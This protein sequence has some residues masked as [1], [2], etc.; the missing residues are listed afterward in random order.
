MQGKIAVED[1]F[2]SP[3]FI[4]QMRSEL[5]EGMHMKNWREIVRLLLDV[6]DDRLRVMDANGVEMMILSL[7]SPGIQA[8]FSAERAV[9]LAVRANDHIAEKIK[10][11]PDRFR[12]FAALP[13][14]DPDAAILELR[15]CMTQM[16]FVGAL[17]NGYSQTDDGGEAVYL[18]HKRYRPFWKEAQALGAPVYIHP[19]DAN[20][21]NLPQDVEQPWLQ[22]SAWGFGVETATHALL[23]MGSGLFDEFPDLNLILGHMG[24]GLTFHMHRADKRMSRSATGT[25][26]LRGFSDYL[27]ENFHFTVSGLY[28]S[29]CLLQL[30]GE[31]GADRV[32]FATDYPYEDMAEAA[33]WFDSPHL[34]VSETD[35]RKIGRDNARKL[36]K[37]D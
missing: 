16:G 13:M 2:I 10:S 8:A 29:Q 34:P 25:P 33:D 1:H 6:E 18:H 11:R 15:R 32:L 24:E 26:M 28:H 37:I 3:D 21:A 12:A 4:D 31:V 27:R 30:L 36:F 19:R 7:T 23:L 5:D 20:P 22:G 35:R 17:I 9:E 14:Q